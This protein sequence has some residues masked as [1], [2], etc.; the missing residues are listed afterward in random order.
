VVFR[1]VTQLNDAVLLTLWLASLPVLIGSLIAL[2]VVPYDICN[3][4]GTITAIG[5]KGT[6]PD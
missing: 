5:S 3:A 4:D 2:I 6:M 1:R